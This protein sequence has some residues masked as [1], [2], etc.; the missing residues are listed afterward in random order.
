MIFLRRSPTQIAA[1]V[2]FAG[3]ILGT[4]AD[5]SGAAGAV[6]GA[7]DL[8]ISNDDALESKLNDIESAIQQGFTTIEQEIAIIDAAQRAQN[9][10]F[11]LNNLDPAAAQAQTVVEQ[12]PQA[13]RVIQGIGTLCEIYPV[14]RHGAIK[15][16]PVHERIELPYLIRRTGHHVYHTTGFD[17]EEIIDLCI[18]I[19]SVQPGAGSP[20]WPPC[21][22]LFK[23]VVA[24]LTYMRHNRTQ[25]EIGESLAY[26]SRLSA[27]P[28][29][30]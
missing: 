3:N 23:S 18:R 5:A 10:L 24:A 22:G 28:Y 29:L 6:V 12:L 4:L 19:N 7:S 26:P 9:I 27:A 11:R 8:F 2:Q 1:P 20:N 25:A 30:P 16:W 13:L 14:Q 21:L 15:R 17:R